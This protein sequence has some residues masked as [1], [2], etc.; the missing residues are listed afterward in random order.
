MVSGEA[1]DLE[2]ALT[3]LYEL[4]SEFDALELAASNAQHKLSI[5]VGQLE[6]LSNSQPIVEVVDDELVDIDFSRG[7][8]LTLIGNVS[9]SPDMKTK[10]ED[11]EVADLACGTEE[12]L[13][14]IVASNAEAMD[15]TD[16]DEPMLAPLTDGETPEFSDACEAHSAED[17]T[18]AACCDVDDSSVQQPDVT[19]TVDDE[20]L[21]KDLS[22]TADNAGHETAQAGEAE[23][24]VEA[25]TSLSDVVPG[26]PEK[27]A[28]LSTPVGSEEAALIE[29]ADTEATI[30][31]DANTRDLFNDEL[32]L[33]DADASEELQSDEDNIVIAALK[34]NPDQDI[35]DVALEGDDAEVVKLL[36]LTSD[37]DCQGSM[38]QP[39]EFDGAAAAAELKQNQSNISA[40][41]EEKADLTSD[42]TAE[43]LAA[44]EADT[45]IT[46]EAPQDAALDVVETDKTSQVTSIDTE[47]QAES[48]AEAEAQSAPETDTV[49][50]FPTT[51]EK[52]VSA[53][54]KPKKRRLAVA[55]TGIAASVAACAFAL[56]MPEFQHLRD[57]PH[58]QDLPQMDQ[59]LQRLSELQR[60][61]A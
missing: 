58:L 27:I 60:F 49:V 38:H 2:T 43:D 44:D 13:D 51:Q 22:C 55:F 6:T 19:A 34:T 48:D 21:D 37:E 24:T 57:L 40:I 1:L 56:Q 3:Q 15:A 5:V 45:Q 59:L 61:L 52:T 23:D 25:S 10:S 46:A 42:T 4:Q 28:Y 20:V 35:D 8:A 31:E 39:I 16:N 54:R 29:A 18:Q 17:D 33:L 50:P 11:D 9:P 47:T 26:E 14:D 41:D 53:A 32:E 12:T 30:S 7:A 36:D